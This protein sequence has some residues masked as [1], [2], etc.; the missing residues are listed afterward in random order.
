MRRLGQGAFAQVYVA[1]D[2]TL[3]RRVAIKV[4]NPALAD[5]RAFLRR[6]AAEA[7]AVAGLRHPHILRVY[8]WGE[9]EGDPYLVM[10]LLEGGSLR[11]YLDEGRRL[12]TAQAA[13]VGADVAG[14]LDYAHRRGLVHR[15]IKPANLIFDDEGRIALADF[16]L[17]RALAEATLTEPS[18]SV[19]GTARYAAPEA[20]HGEALDGRADVYALALV[21]V[22]ATTGQV[23]FA[24][25]TSLATLMRRLREPITV[26]DGV[27]PLGPVLEAAG[28]VDPRERLDAATLAARLEGVAAA[29][30]PPDRL[31]LAGPLM[32][33]RST[34]VD[35]Q[36]TDIPGRAVLF[37]LEEVEEDLPARPPAA[38]LVEPPPPPPAARPPRPDFPRASS[39]PSP[40]APSTAGRTRGRRRHRGMKTAPLTVLTVA[41]L[42][43]GG[44]ATYVLTRPQPTYTVPALGGRTIAD[45]AALLRR[46]H[47]DL[48]VSGRAY[49]P[50]APVGRVLTQHPAGGRLT[51][52]EPVDVVVSEGPRP[53]AVPALGGK[54]LADA[55][56]ALSAA[57]LRVGAVTKTTSMTVPDGSVI[58]AMPAGGTLLPRSSVALVISTGKP[59]V[60]VPKL[61]GADAG[62]FAGASTALHAF[63]LPAT[64]TNQYS[65]DV[66]KGQVIVTNP[67]PGVTVTVG[68]PIDVEVSLGPHLVVVP[69]V[70]GDSV[71]TA[72]ETLGASGFSVSSVNGSPLGAV[73]S[74]F[75]AMGQSIL[76]GSSVTL[77]TG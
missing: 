11:S 42:A 76:Y 53:V 68:T 7:Q 13:R 47:L 2:V 62:S 77:T 56:A 12:S 23:P 61:A 73:T 10:E 22:E 69:N 24:M 32:G 18:G 39:G 31:V 45:A 38:P 21:L 59:T 51:S 29:L 34:E 16:G 74:T 40:L 72:A 15:D 55:T 28:T 50:T 5:E 14:A 63:G 57:D 30:A 67:A 33:G 6:F 54:T 65:N 9:D 3:R 25:D 46:S 52:G 75:P 19:V 8:D 58:K 35:H 70:Y 41:V 4:L 43:G 37:D 66:P 44:G 48:V 1:D 64:Q 71:T 17:A 27:G 36:P 49:D 60:V 26:P 20:L